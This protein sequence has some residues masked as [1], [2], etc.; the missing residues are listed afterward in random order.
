[1]PIELVIL[2]LAALLQAV[3]LVAMAIPVNR[4]LGPRYTAGSRD[5]P[6]TPTGVAGRLLRAYD[7]H[8]EALILF[9]VA[10]VVVVLGGGGSGFTE[11]CAWAYLAARI[12]Y[13]PAYA[14][15]VFLLRSVIWSIG[16]FATIAML[17]AGLW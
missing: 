13:V 11:A 16:F 3:Q 6:R 17:V 9:A 4:Q 8:N 1:M 14:S 15:G 12:A 7:N 10:V 2:G 5:E